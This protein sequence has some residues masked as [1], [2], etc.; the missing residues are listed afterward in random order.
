MCRDDILC[1]SILPPVMG[2]GLLATGDYAGAP[3]HQLFCDEGRRWGIASDPKGMSLHV[4]QAASPSGIC[5]AVSDAEL[6]NMRHRSL[7]QLLSSS[8]G[9]PMKQAATRS[10]SPLAACPKL[11]RCCAFC[12]HLSGAACLVSMSVSIVATICTSA[13]CGSVLYSLH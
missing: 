9:L 4:L 11:R 13:R 12:C 1:M 5:R 3:P 6:C 10:S 8:C 7:R 2:V